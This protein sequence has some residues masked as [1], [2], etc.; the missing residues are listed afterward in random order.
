M[1]A[2]RMLSLPR[3]IGHAGGG[4]PKVGAVSD[5]WSSCRE[6]SETFCEYNEGFRYH[7]THP[8]HYLLS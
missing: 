5:A 6:L 8:T 2:T 4:A 1:G 7:F 3:F